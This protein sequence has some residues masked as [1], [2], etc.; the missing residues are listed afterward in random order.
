MENHLSE[1][2]QR[3]AVRMIGDVRTET[4]FRAFVD[5]SLPTAENELSFAPFDGNQAA[6]RSAA[7]CIQTF[8][9]R[10]DNP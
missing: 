3:S 4:S 2:D 8:A 9:E 1:H 5:W 10:D 7:D 6:A